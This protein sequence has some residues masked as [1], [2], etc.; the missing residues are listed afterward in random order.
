MPVTGP[1]YWNKTGVKFPVQ[2]G[3]PVAITQADFEECCCPCDLA[4]VVIA[5]SE[6]S[7]SI[8]GGS[9]ESATPL[10]MQTWVETHYYLFVNYS[11]PINDANTNFRVFADLETF[12]GIASLTWPGL[13]RRKANE[14]DEFS[15]GK[16][17]S[18]DFIGEWV[19]EDLAAAFT[20]LRWTVLGSG[21]AITDMYY[22]SGGYV[23]PVGDPETFGSAMGKAIAA[24][25]SDS[26][27]SAA[28]ITPVKH[29]ALRGKT[30]DT[31]LKSATIYATRCVF[32][33][34]SAYVPAIVSKT[35]ALYCLMRSAYYPAT[36]L[37]IPF[38]DQGD[39]V[40]E[41]FAAI[42]ESVAITTPQDVYFTEFT[43][44]QMPGWDPAG[45]SWDSSNCQY[46][47]RYYSSEVLVKWNFT[48][49]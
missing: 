47:Y 17:Q 42:V 3:K 44:E 13:W 2:S 23:V 20:A 12:A 48:I 22:R 24:W 34:Q 18:G 15:Y 11:N 39:P 43:G 32:Y 38:S 10:E 33:I 7:Q 9:V 25:N 31:T 26:W 41:G 29:T 21:L 30:T 16:Y 37:E 14:S 40:E 35:F 6:H 1:I 49:C 46:G 36:A 28:G 4:C 27:H 19:C 45:P 8:G 5:Y